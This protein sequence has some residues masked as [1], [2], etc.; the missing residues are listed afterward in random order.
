M[1]PFF[2]DPDDLTRL[3]LAMMLTIGFLCFVGLL[4]LHRPPEGNVD[5]VFQMLGTIATGLG[6][7]LAYY[8]KGKR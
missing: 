6:T 4:I 2:K 5:M 8:F 1:T 3:I 7:I